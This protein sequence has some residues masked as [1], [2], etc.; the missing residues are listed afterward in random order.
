MRHNQDLA[1]QLRHSK[2][3]KGDILCKVYTLHVFILIFGSTTSKMTQTLKKLPRYF[4]GSKLMFFGV[5][6]MSCFNNL[7]IVQS[8]LFVCHIS[9][10][11]FI[12]IIKNTEHTVNN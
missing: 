8:I 9:L 11:D 7:P 1:T 12:D 5:W 10:I 4:F 3:F 2:T 6:K